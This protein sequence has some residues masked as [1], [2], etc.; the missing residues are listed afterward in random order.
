MRANA[1][2]EQGRYEEAFP[3]I[4]ECIEI[5]PNNPRY[6]FLLGNILLA[7]EKPDIASR[8]YLKAISLNP[9]DPMFHNN[10]GIAFEDAGTPEKAMVAYRKALKLQ[11][12][13]RAAQ[14]NFLLLSIQTD[15]LDLAEKILEGIP[16][17][18][19]ETSTLQC[20]Q[21]ILRYKETGKKTFFL[22]AKEISES[23]STTL[24]RDAL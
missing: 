8:A 2:Y 9:T 24:T 3:D 21:L 14:T 17:K 18:D 13:H 6:H 12:N 1:Y 20:A 23:L 19:R 10:L 22:R 11:P 15:Q 7:L 16:P 4:F 5:A